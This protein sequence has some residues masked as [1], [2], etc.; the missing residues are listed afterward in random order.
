MPQFNNS[1]DYELNQSI[2]R[3]IHDIN[4]NKC[5][6]KFQT[7]SHLYN[8][9]IYLSKKITTQ[10]LQSVRSH[11]NRPAD[12]SIV[13]HPRPSNIDWKDRVGTKFLHV[14][15]PV[16]LPSHGL[17]NEPFSMPQ[18]W[19]ISGFR[20]RNPGLNASALSSASGKTFCKHPSRDPWL[21]Q[22]LQIQRHPP[23]TLR[24]AR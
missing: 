10:N 16:D 8:S 22:E 24:A 19:W 1:I 14:Y 2:T 11:D 6:W 18:E 13:P 15:H 4:Q 21:L 9:M 12:T 17:V 5:K 3:Y 7:H 23:C 20:V